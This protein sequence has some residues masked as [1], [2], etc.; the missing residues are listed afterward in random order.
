MRNINKLYD[1][2][3]RMVELFE[4]NNDKSDNIKKS[5]INKINKIKTIK[6]DV[7][8]GDLD[9][10]VVDDSKVD[11]KI[12]SEY[13]S[14][15]AND[16]L[17]LLRKIALV[18][19]S[20]S[21]LQKHMFD[22]QGKDLLQVQDLSTKRVRSSEDGAAVNKEK[23]RLYSQMPTK[24]FKDLLSK[25]RYVLNMGN[26]SE[27]TSPDEA[28][29]LFKWLDTRSFNTI[30]LNSSGKVSKA[31]N[32][33]LNFLGRIVSEKGL[34]DDEAKML[35][36]FGEGAKNSA[37]R[38]L[39]DWYKL[40]SENLLLDLLNM[41]PTPENIDIISEG[42]NKAMRQLVDGKWNPSQNLSP[43]FLQVVKNHAKNE[44][45]SLTKYAPNLDAAARIFSDMLNKEGE[46]SIMSRKDPSHSN[47]ADEVE[48]MG[49]GKYLYKYSNLENAVNDLKD[50]MTI[51]NHHLKPSNLLISKSKGLFSSE[52]QA[53]SYMAPEDLE[54]LQQVQD[55][56]IEDF[57]GG[58]EKEIRDI[59][60]D[61]VEFMSK[62]ENFVGTEELL[63]K[64]IKKPRAVSSKQ[65]STSD[66]PDSKS[67]KVA[68][69]NL[70]NFLYNFV[71]PTMINSVG[72][73]ITKSVEDTNPKSPTFGKEIRVVDTS[74]TERDPANKAIEA[75]RDIEKS[76]N[77]SSEV[78]N[79]WI[80][81]QNNKIMDTLKRLRPEQSEEELEK[82]A[83]E[84]GLLIKGNAQDL[85]NGLKV[86]LAK[87]PE[88][89][90]KMTELF[91]QTS[92][93][94][95][96][97]ELSKDSLE[98]RVRAKIRKIL[99]ESFVIKEVEDVE[100]EGESIEDLDNQIKIFGD[101]FSKATNYN[102][103][104]LDEEV[105]NVIN[106][107]GYKWNYENGVDGQH[108]YISSVLASI[109]S[110][111]SSSQQRKVLEYVF[112]SFLPRQERSRLI[113]Q[114][115]YKYS[116]NYEGLTELVWNSFINPESNGKL[117][118]VNALEQY[119]PK[120]SF[121]QFMKRRLMN[122]ISNALKGSEYSFVDKTLKDS[123]EWGEYE[124]G[125]E[126]D[127]ANAMVSQ[128]KRV[129]KKSIDAPT[130]ERDD[131]SGDFSKPSFL[132]LKSDD[133]ESKIE[134]LRDKIDSYLSKAEN[135]GIL[136]NSELGLL[137]AIL[138][139]GDE[140]ME[141][142]K[143]N[144]ELLGTKVGKSASNIGTMMSNIVKKMTQAREKGNI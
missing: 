122:A 116:G 69:E 99:R 54:S 124:V 119:E 31:G 64:E 56:K 21:N 104:E 130:R 77:I 79:T 14:Y 10:F 22:L 78:M 95:Y 111:L 102:R 96:E 141:S 8:F 38:I 110:S 120:G 123:P 57:D 108:N 136:S 18:S 132:D 55:V 26:N 29:R 28:G 27:E 143:I 45:K 98:E 42:V 63:G 73:T 41:K 112:L 52:R 118:M 60:G 113:G 16:D 65:H 71:F 30:G 103:E 70:V 34:K 87:N 5:L 90:K 13:D 62:S 84:K 74:R 9:D 126:D 139:H 37:G 91:L 58:A 97:Q 135:L 144:Y 33:T 35:T 92:A 137:K 93:K 32:A 2:V 134:E 68:K 4:S 89:F 129:L 1:E 17:P 82:L 121:L 142:D 49:G 39:Y 88:V 24:E 46:I 100:E 66:K 36:A 114:M 83:K 67:A 133:S 59:L 85:W 107:E 76:G 117:L 7:D 3:S 131:A 101:R 80:D 127:D 12:D 109:Y 53:P 94:G 75:V 11:G 15:S 20:I 51:K 115:S 50:S 47:S 105:K 61:A 125:K 25:G 48:E 140:V 43:W 106:G 44:L 23:K 6:E 72:K 81:S 40:V 86:F 138:E 19:R 128:R